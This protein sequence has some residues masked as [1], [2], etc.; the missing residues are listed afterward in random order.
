MQHGYL[1]ICLWLGTTALVDKENLKVCD[2]EEMKIKGY[3]KCLLR[4]R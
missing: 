3:I 1:V 4:K 2:L